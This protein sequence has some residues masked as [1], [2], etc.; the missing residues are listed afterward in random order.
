VQACYRITDAR[1]VLRVSGQNKGG[2]LTALES[3]RS[4]LAGRRLLATPLEFG[5]LHCVCALSDCGGWTP[6]SLARIDAPF[7]GGQLNKKLS[8][9]SPTPAGQ[10]RPEQSAVKP[11]HSKKSRSPRAT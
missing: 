5:L 7:F 6:L 4:Q 2:L 3:R 1:S 11:A 8:A 10:A 9:A